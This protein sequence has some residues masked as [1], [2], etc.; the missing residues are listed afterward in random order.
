M[1]SL[2]STPDRQLRRQARRRQLLRIGHWRHFAIAVALAAPFFYFTFIPL[3][4]LPNHLA[5]LHLLFDGGASPYYAAHWRLLPNLALEGFVFL[6]HGFVPIDFAVRLFLAITSAQLFLGTWALNSVLFGRETR[7][8]LVGGL[9]VLNEPLLLGLANFSFGIGMALWVFALWLRWRDR[10]W[11]W[12]VFSVLGTLLLLCHLFAFG[13]YL[14]AIISF[15]L[16]AHWR[17]LTRSHAI[18][19]VLC[20]GLR[21]AVPL[22]PPLILY[23]TAMPREIEG[24]SALYAPWQQKLAALASVIGTSNTGFDLACLALLIAGVILI[25]RNLTLSPP[26]IAPLASF[27]AGF[28]LL[29]HALGAAT[30]IDYRIPT[31]AVLFL[32]GSVSW[33]GD[34]ERL[35]RRA[36]FVVLGLL[37]LRLA[38]LC[39][40]WA[41][42]QPIYGEYHRAFA[43]LPFGAKLL[44][45]DPFSGS[46]PLSGPPLGHIAALAVS[47]RGAFIPSLFANPV[48]QPL[49]YAPAYAALQEA[50][51]TTRNIAFYDY[52][53]LIKPELFHN[54]ALPAYET[55]DRGQTFI[56]GKIIH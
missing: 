50:N 38:V 16:A 47:E 41:A 12:A 24:A 33:K 13:A 2:S 29:P 44:P 37:A 22:A 30:F 8:A 17:E 49:V 42:W 27:A 9:F 34:C 28:L 46:I 52:I 43:K 51:P 39:T 26:M 5:R 53:L 14:V 35:R 40:Q 10:S 36:E 25:R 7:F 23:L 55:I 1:T 3:H 48:Q 32:V 4:D 54:P 31:I 19:S 6:L 56:L 45:L 21:D 11:A 15:S 20:Q 18:R